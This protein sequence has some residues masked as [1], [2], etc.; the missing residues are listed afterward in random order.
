MG[1]SGGYST[2]TAPC[3]P[4][5]YHDS[6]QDDRGLSCRQP[7]AKL[8]RIYA[9][10]IFARAYTRAPGFH[11][12]SHPHLRR[13]LTVI[14]LD[15]SIRPGR[16]PLAPI[17]SRATRIAALRTPAP[18]SSDRQSLPA[19][20][21]NP[22]FYYLRRLERSPGRSADYFPVLRSSFQTRGRS[23]PDSAFHCLH[24]L[25]HRGSLRIPV[26]YPS[27]A[28]RAPTRTGLSKVGG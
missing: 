12:S 9:C 14:D 13:R 1:L 6:A 17:R 21:A 28:R 11:R 15:Q 22:P 5:I 7:K 20:Q 3:K 25:T 2:R 4:T 23:A 16:G 18:R 27:V 24:G 10:N 8:T 19:R 26:G